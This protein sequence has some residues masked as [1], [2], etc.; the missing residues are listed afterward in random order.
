MDYSI[1]Q[2]GK[3][4]DPSKYTIC[5]KYKTFFTKENDLVLDFTYQYN[6]TF[7]TG[8]SCTFNTGS[9]CTFKTGHYCKFITSDD[10]TFNTD[11]NPSFK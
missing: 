4:L 1:T 6:W 10:C 3:P 2:H 7:V 11:S 8:S 9:E 5:E